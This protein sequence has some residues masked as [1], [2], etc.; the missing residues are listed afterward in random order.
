MTPQDVRDP[1]FGYTLSSEEFPASELAR[2]ASIAENAGFD[3]LTISDHYHPWTTTQG[4]SPYV[5]TSLG[6]VAARTRSV[7][8]GPASRVRS[9]A[10]TP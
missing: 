2:Q 10:S 8:S 6:A 9:C 4:H 5:W 7:R 3:F 1:S